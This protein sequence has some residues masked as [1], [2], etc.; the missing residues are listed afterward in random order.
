LAVTADISDKIFASGAAAAI[1]T[2]VEIGVGTRLQ[3]P[4]IEMHLKIPV[5]PT[6][7]RQLPDQCSG[8][9]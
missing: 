3:S 8:D 4:I 1:E 7:Y 9:I 5:I 6:K 2:G